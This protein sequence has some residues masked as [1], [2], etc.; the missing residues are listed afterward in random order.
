MPIASAAAESA[1]KILLR[2]R[3]SPAHLRSETR[4]LIRLAIAQIQ[5]EARGASS[6]H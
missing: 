3:N 4:R 6:V 5:A 1:L 2:R